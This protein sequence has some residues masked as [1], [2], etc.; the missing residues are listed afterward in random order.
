MAS[1]Q[2]QLSPEQAGLKLFIGGLS[3]D[4]PDDTFIK[5]FS[6]FGKLTDSVVMRHPDGKSRGFGFVTYEDPVVAEKVLATKDL[7]I[8]G[9]KIDPKRAIPRDAA[10]SKDDPSR[11]KTKKVFVGGLAA[12]TPRE[13][14]E[15]YFSKFGKITDCII[16]TEKGSGRPRGFGF[17]T[18]D[19]EDSAEKVVEV[20]EHV[21]H[22]KAVDC[23]K[24]IPKDDSPPRRGGGRDRLRRDGRRRG[25][26]RYDR[27]ERFD[28]NADRYGRGGRDR[29]YDRRRAPYSGRRDYE[30]YGAFE[31]YY[32]DLEYAR[33]PYGYGD[34][35]DRG[36]GGAG[37]YGGW[38]R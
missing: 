2:Q 36:Y 20:K 7:E 32:G 30:D 3:W 9:R 28:R 10:P 16:M 25:G 17:V 6:T 12:D 5:Y 4:T 8:D 38:R 31:D 35:Y 33:D 37:G 29:D 1:D 21:I 34:G 19:T 14:F 22:G 24:A 15:S 18:Y 27:S 13:E 26:D 23:K 11:Q